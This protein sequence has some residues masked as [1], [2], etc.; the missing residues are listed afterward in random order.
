MD[1][2]DTSKGRK[3]VHQESDSSDVDDTHSADEELDNEKRLKK[4][5][6]KI[7]V[8]T[9]GIKRQKPAEKDLDRSLEEDGRNS[10]EDGHSHSSTE[11]KVKVLSFSIATV[12]SCYY[13]VSHTFVFLTRRINEKRPLKYMGNK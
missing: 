4:E 6:Q 1:E 8:S 9:K 3:R 2:E 7:K 13:I 12:S 10:S 11:E 5:A